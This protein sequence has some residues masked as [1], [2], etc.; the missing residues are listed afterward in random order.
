LLCLP[1]KLF[2]YFFFVIFF[3]E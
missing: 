2:I 1:H 3:I